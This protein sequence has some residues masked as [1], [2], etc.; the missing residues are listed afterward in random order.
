MRSRN[1]VNVM[2]VIWCVFVC[3]LDAERV[4]AQGGNTKAAG[5]SGGADTADILRLRKPTG[6]GSQSIVKTPEFRT[7]GAGSVKPPGNWVQI[8]AKFDTSPE[9][10]DELTFQFY[11][12]AKDA[13]GGYSLYKNSVRYVDIE[14][15]KDHMATMYV[16]PATVKR[17]GLLV[18]VA[19]EIS[20]GGKLI[21]EDSDTSESKL[22]KD[23]WKREWKGVIAREGCLVDR[24]QSPFAL[25]NIDDYEVIK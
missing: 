10:V 4:L 24:S 18:A 9:W 5:K 16:R 19:V 21:A 2:V 6:I 20:H 22:G 12:I 25:V 11:A 7:G 17:Y 14:R 3:T 13:K 15:G 1:V 23:W 8:T